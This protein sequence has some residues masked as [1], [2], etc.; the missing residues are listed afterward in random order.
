MKLLTA[1]VPCY[2]EEKVLPLFYQEIIRIADLLKNDVRMEFLFV[3]DGSADKTLEIL[4]SF[5]SVDKRVKIISFSRN[6]GKEAA[7]YA[8]LEHSKGDYVAILDADLQH[9]PEMLIQMYHGIVDEGYDSVA[10][11]RV[12]RE[13]EPKLRSFFSRKFYKVLTKLSKI[14]IVEGSVDYRL[15][16]RQ[17]V[18]AILQMS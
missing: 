3:N 15:M 18:N 8:G 10:A 9:P 5:R 12:T 17:M 7:M 2:N 6:F 14:D 4:K 11:K 16:S 1:I 13:G